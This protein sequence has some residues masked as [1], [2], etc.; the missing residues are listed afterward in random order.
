[1]LHFGL[2]NQPKCPKTGKLIFPKVVEQQ[3][4]G[5]VDVTIIVVADFFSILCAKYY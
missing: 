1:M 5:E 3:Y 2:S 4:A